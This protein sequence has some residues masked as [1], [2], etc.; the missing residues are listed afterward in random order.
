V[1]ERVKD[2]L[3][4]GENISQTAQ[5]VETGNADIGIVAQSLAVSPTMQSAGRYIEIPAALYDPIDQGAI[6]IKS[7]QKQSAAKGFLDYL[8]QPAAQEIM[9]KYGFSE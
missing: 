7:S 5:F 4:L 2:K 1:Y 9:K 8:K 3:V 6:V